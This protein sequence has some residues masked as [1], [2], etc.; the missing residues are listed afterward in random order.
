MSGPPT[1]FISYSWD[2]DAHRAWVKELAERLVLNGVHVKLDQWD[3]V[4]GDSLTQFM[5]HEISASDFVLVICTPNYAQNRPL[6]RA[7]SVMSS[8]SFRGA[9]RPELSVA[10]SYR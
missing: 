8:K 1:V 3:L 7:A 10:S 4:P 5:E 2:N 6:E 9:S